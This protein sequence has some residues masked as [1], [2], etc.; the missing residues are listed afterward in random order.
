MKTKRVTINPDWKSNVH[1]EIL[2]MSFEQMKDHFG[3]RLSV[4]LFKG[5][6]DDELWHVLQSA[7]GWGEYQYHKHLL[8][9][10]RK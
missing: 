2:D 4:A 3:G 10:S 5:K 9:E 1:Q 6:F 8:D 7:I